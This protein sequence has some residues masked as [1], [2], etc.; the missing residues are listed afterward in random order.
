MSTPSI[1]V[2]GFEPWADADENPTLLVLDELRRTNDLPG[3]LTAVPLPVDSDG[4]GPRVEAVLDRVR[5]DLWIS[6][7]LAPGA[8]VV[9]VER[10]AANVRDFAVPDNLGRQ[11]GGEPVAPDGPAA[12][13]STLPVKRIT[14]AL[15]ESGVPARLSNSASTYLC[16]QVMYTVLHLIDRKGLPTRAGFLHVPAHPALA[17]RQGRGRA[18]MPSMAVD[19]VARAVRVAAEVA[20]GTMDDSRAPTWTS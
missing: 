9:A 18:E 15:R 6:L 3:T 20:L 5:P 2:T 11:Y 16:N 4:L 13:L 17:A 19:L 1:V 14:E 8:A 12:Y 10:I 7:G